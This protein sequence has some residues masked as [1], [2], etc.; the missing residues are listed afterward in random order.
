MLAAALLITQAKVAQFEGP[1]APLS[2]LL[3]AVGKQFGEEWTSSPAIAREMM[4]VYFND[5]SAEDARKNI[6]WAVHGQWTRDGAKWRLQRPLA[7]E[8]NLAEAARGLREQGYRDNLKV[9]LNTASRSTYD[10]N[11][12]I[13][14]IR[15]EIQNGGMPDLDVHSENGYFSRA[16][17]AIQK[18]ID[19]AWLASLEENTSVVLSNRPN[20]RQMSLTGP[21]ATA[22]EEFVQEHN[23]L[24]NEGFAIATTDHLRPKPIGQ[25]DKRFVRIN[26]DAYGQMKLGLGF[27]DADGRVRFAGTKYLTTYFFGSQAPQPKL[28]PAKFATPK[29]LQ[30]IS[31]G[32]GQ[33]NLDPALQ[34]RLLRPDLN[35]PLD[36][37][38]GEALRSYAKAARVNMA[39]AMADDMVTFRIAEPTA[40]Q[41]RFL[42]AFFRQ[43]CSVEGGWVR[44]RYRDPIKFR[45]ELARRDVLAEYLPLD[46]KLET[47]PFDLVA[48]AHA[49]GPDTALSN[50][51]NIG[52]LGDQRNSFTFSSG[53]IT[54][55]WGRMTP[56]ERQ[57]ALNGGLSVQAASPRVREALDTDQSS[58][59]TYYW[60]P[61]QNFKMER[62]EPTE[63]ADRPPTAKIGFAVQES[64]VAGLPKTGQFPDN[65]GVERLE[66]VEAESLAAKVV[67]QR[68]SVTSLRLGSRKHY[69][70][71]LLGP[72]GEELE[73]QN[74][75]D[76]RWDL[77]RRLSVEEFPDEFR[78]AYRKRLAELRGGG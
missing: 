13:A 55:V 2:T 65:D 21:I 71:K 47:I 17:V 6:A 1:V 8:R 62:I 38:I 16:M 11:A 15:K 3:P 66:A 69:T 27:A 5:T 24:I 42:S 49:N 51:V 77:S 26:L 14:Q 22:V 20:S 31:Q 29:D 64:L 4:L 40:N 56:A 41:D 73:Q 37:V 70:M 52:Y 9:A 18:A 74:A 35:E 59:M 33:A 60:S 63:R 32:R 44:N 61:G 78:T 39:V 30:E 67:H 43:E 36:I 72:N 54:K 76:D 48:A 45:I 12:Q 68:V 75:D 34:K 58:A 19:P 25:G 10:R 46:G 28:P 23:A 57:R 50:Y 7:T 53:L